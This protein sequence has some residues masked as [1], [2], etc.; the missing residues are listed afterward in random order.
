MGKIKINS[1]PLGW[2]LQ[3]K[4]RSY[5]NHAGVQGGSLQWSER[6]EGE[7]GVT[8]INAVGVYSCAYFGVLGMEPRASGLLGKL[9]TT[10]L[11][12]QF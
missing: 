5:G 12:A 10:E 7:F 11:H 1:S 9:S 2:E 8:E 4:S 3:G 6:G